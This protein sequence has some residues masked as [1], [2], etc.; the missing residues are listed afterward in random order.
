MMPLASYSSQ[1]PS[2]I[3]VE[4]YRGKRPLEDRETEGRIILKL[5]L[6][7]REMYMTDSR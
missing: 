5:Y 7:E 4:K 2:R 6:G 3:L 1:L